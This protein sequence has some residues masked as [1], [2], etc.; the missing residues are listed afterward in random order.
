[1]TAIRHVCRDGKQYVAVSTGRSNSRAALTRLT[2][3]AVPAD[4]P[5]KLF[6]FAL[7]D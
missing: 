4:G 3:E 5:N 6:V 1:M 2:P 7:P